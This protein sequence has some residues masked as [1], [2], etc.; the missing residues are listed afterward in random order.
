M[1]ATLPEEYTHPDV[2]AAAARG[3]DG[4]AE[5]ETDPTRINWPERQA[6][7]AIPF[8]V[9]GGRP[10][11]PVEDTAVLRGRN[12]MGFWGENLMADAIVTV[13]WCGVRYILLVERDDGYGWAVPGGHVE[14]GE[15]GLDAARRE[16]EEETSLDVTAGLCC[17]L[18]ARYVR[19]PRSSR[20]AWAVTIPVHVALPERHHAA[21]PEVRAGDDARRAEWVQADT[22]GLLELNLRELQGGEVFAAHREM[23]RDLLDAP[24][25]PGHADVRPVAVTCREP[26]DV[27]EACRHLEVLEGLPAAQYGGILAH[28]LA[29]VTHAVLALRETVADSG[30]GLADILDSGLVNIADEVTGAVTDV[31]ESVDGASVPAMVRRLTRRA[32]PSRVASPIGGSSSR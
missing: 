5:A 9:A 3:G 1:T 6:R 23:L 28:G 16:L 32:R 24:C 19:D 11:N 25:G 20:E 29:A 27:K 18:P 14:A 13:T 26:A 15:S 30:D 21:P 22:Y 7:A 12:E 31:A 17:Q 2:Y 8:E 4:W 10:V